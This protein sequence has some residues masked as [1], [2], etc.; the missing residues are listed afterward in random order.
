MCFLFFTSFYQE[1]QYLYTKISPVA[2]LI[3]FQKTFKIDT[4]TNAIGK[5]VE[6]E[7]LNPTFYKDKFE[8]DLY[9]RT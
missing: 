7:M 8:S 4:K 5:L 1:V 3:I 9:C 2:A 6:L